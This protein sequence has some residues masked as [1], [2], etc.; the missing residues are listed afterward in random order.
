MEQNSIQTWCDFSAICLEFLCTMWYVTDDLNVEY[1]E[2]N[3]VMI[4][5][6]R[7][8]NELR[9]TSMVVF[10]GRSL[11][12][13]MSLILDCGFS[14]SNDGSRFSLLLTPK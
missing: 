14:Y 8:G 13:S 11:T 9:K 1:A 6:T 4:L 3:L 5:A 10:P 12:I 7:C 2:M